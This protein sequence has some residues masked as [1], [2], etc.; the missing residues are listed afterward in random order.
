MTAAKAVSGGGDGEWAISA[1]VGRER[2]QR[3]ARRCTSIV[4][5]DDKALSVRQAR[6]SIERSFGPHGATHSATSADAPPPL[7]IKGVVS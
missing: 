2:A 5:V 7:G 4:V 1:A 3:A 6:A